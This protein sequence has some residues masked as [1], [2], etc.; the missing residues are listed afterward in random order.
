[1]RMGRKRSKDG[2]HLQ[3][4]SRVARFR[5]HFLHQWFTRMETPV[6][7][8]YVGGEVAEHWMELGRESQAEAESGCCYS[9]RA[10]A[11]A[12]LRRATKKVAS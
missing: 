7:G 3:A 11:A 12:P 10:P 8:W 2:S 9:E 6:R 5:C 1:M 4:S